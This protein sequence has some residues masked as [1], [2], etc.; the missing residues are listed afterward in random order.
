MIGIHP[1]IKQYWEHRYPN[2]DIIPSKDCSYYYYRGDE[3]EFSVIIV[4]MK[5]GRAKNLQF[6]FDK[7]WYYEGEMLRVLRLKAFI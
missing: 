6:L 3:N 7:K 5:H 1:E 4:A 2:R